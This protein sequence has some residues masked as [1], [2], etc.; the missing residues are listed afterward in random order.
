MKVLTLDHLFRDDIVGIRGHLLLT[1][2]I[3]LWDLFAQ[4]C[5]IAGYAIIV[6]MAGEMEVSVNGRRQRIAADTLAVNFPENVLQVVSHRDVEAYAVIMSPQCFD[7]LH[8]D[9]SELS[10]VYSDFRAHVVFRLPHSEVVPL[11]HY[12]ALLR[13]NAAGYTPGR[14]TVV[15]GLLRAGILQLFDIVQSH[16]DIA[17]ETMQPTPGRTAQIFSDF[18][19]LLAAECVEERTVAHYADRLCLTPRH[20][21]AVI[22]RY[23]GRS[24]SEWIADY[25]II[26]ARRLLAQPSLSV[27]EVA[28]RLHFTSQS[29]FGK[30]FKKTAG[31]SPVEFRHSPGI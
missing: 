9:L 19:S 25:V 24:V 6:C 2:S 1:H 22:K 21:S 13:H 18:L 16:A 26:E 17:V 28:R 12:F 8:I 29:A 4:P 11:Y 27:Q 5:R 14:R 20:L 31:M 10:R 23:S 30:Y 3:R 15:R 7:D